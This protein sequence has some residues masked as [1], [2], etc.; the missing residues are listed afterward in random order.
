[1]HTTLDVLRSNIEHIQRGD[2]DF[3]VLRFRDRSGLLLRRFG[4]FRLVRS[5]SF[6]ISSSCKFVLLVHSLAALSII[7]LVASI[8]AK[9]GLDI[10]MEVNI[11][12]LAFG[13]GYFDSDIVAF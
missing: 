6:R 5:D 1:M 3:F 13:S 9:D 8:M 11:T 10:P 7:L 12:V 2:L 4:T